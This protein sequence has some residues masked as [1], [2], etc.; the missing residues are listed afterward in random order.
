MHTA[1]A[2]KKA[3]RA[4]AWESEHKLWEILK[5]GAAARNRPKKSVPPGG[6]LCKAFG[7]IVS[8]DA[9]VGGMGFNKLSR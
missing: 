3:A 1:H 5:N 6:L 2:Q 9:P 7:R 8:D 4:T